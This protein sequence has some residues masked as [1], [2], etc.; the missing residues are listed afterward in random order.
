MEMPIS[1][2][3]SLSCAL[4]L[5]FPGGNSLEAEPGFTTELAFPGQEGK[6]VRGLVS[7]PDGEKELTYKRFGGPVSG[8]LQREFGDG[9]RHAALGLQL[10]PGAALDE[11]VAGALLSPSRASMGPAP[12]KYA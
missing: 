7:L 9:G 8:R 3:L 4:G 12:A 1:L 6:V 10:R 5:L 2:R 11:A